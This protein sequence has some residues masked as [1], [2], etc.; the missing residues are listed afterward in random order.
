MNDVINTVT[1]TEIIN[2][3]YKIWVIDNFLKKKV[4]GKIE[5]EWPGNDDP[6]WFRG[7]PEIDG[8]RNILEQGMLAISSLDK[9]PPFISEIVSYFHSPDFTKIV[10]QITGME[11]LEPDSTM[12]WSGL[13]VMLPDSFQLIH[14]DARKNPF[15]GKNKKLTLLY[16]LNEGYKDSD[17]GSLEIWDDSMQ[18]C[19]HK[20]KPLHNRL[21]I[22]ENSD[23]SYHGVPVVNS[24]RRAIT[25]SLLANEPADNRSKALFVAR[26]EDADEVRVLGHKRAYIPD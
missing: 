2:N 24:I 6:R 7:R 25:F 22:F 14:S 17:E 12:R 21:V 11:G 3:P 4:W 16:Y 19:A 13:R 20:I 9:M 23:S 1:P 10:L 5:E 26:P 15:N 8:K 18:N